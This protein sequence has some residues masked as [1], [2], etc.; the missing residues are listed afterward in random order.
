MLAP[1]CCC[2][3]VACGGKIEGAGTVVGATL[4]GPAPEGPPAP[5]PKP[6]AASCSRKAS[7][8]RLM[9]P[10]LMWGCAGG[11]PYTV[12]APAPRWL[13]G[14][15]TAPTG[16]PSTSVAGADPRYSRIAG[17]KQMLGRAGAVNQR[18]R[19]RLQ[20]VGVSG[21]GRMEGRARRITRIRHLRGR[22]AS[23]AGRVRARLGRLPRPPASVLSSAMHG[24]RCVG[25]VV[26]ASRSTGVALAHG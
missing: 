21:E 11:C 5:A 8:G 25:S 19:R 3:V 20:V 17:L 26:A 4:S 10:M 1:C 7:S 16:P 2:C 18:P 6:G 22:R 9:P 15:S 12:T 14:E 23:R 13:A 24:A